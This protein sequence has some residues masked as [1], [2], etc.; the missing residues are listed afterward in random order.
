MKK[1]NEEF[2]CAFCEW[3]TVKED[4][5]IYCKKTQKNMD[6]EGFCRHFIYDFIKRTAAPKPSLPAIDP[7]LFE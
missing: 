6:A 4:G 3:A 1:K 2:I 5:S 7:S